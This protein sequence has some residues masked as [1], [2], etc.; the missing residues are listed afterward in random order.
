[1]ITLFKE[2]ENMKKSI[3]IGI[4]AVGI[5][6]LFF[7]FWENLSGNTPEFAKEYSI[8]SLSCDRRAKDCT[9]IIL[10]FMPREEAEQ[11]IPKYVVQEFYK[12]GKT[13]IIFYDTINAGTNFTYN[14]IIKNPLIEELNYYQE[15]EN[16]VVEIK[17]KGAF[18]PA[19]ITANEYAVTIRLKEG[20]QDYPV[21]FDQ[22][23]AEN[24]AVYP[25]FRKISFKTALKSPL[26][27][28]IIQL[29]NKTIEPAMTEIS[30]NQYLFEFYGNIAKDKEY[31]IKAIITDEKDRITVKSWTFEGQIFVETVLGKDR[32]KYLGWWGEINANGVSVRKKPESSSEKLGTFSSINRVKVLK[33]VSGENIDDNNLWYEIDG[34]VYPG[35]YVFSEYVTPI[36][37]P[38]PPQKFTIPG[39]VEK[40]E[41]WIDVDLTKK[42]ITL[43][44]YDKPVFSSY[45]SPGREENPTATGTFRVWYKLEKARMKGGPP[46]HQYKYDLAD[47]PNVLYYEGSYAIHGTYWH[48]KFG[49]QQSAGCTNLTRGDA[50]FIFGRVNPKLGPG[51]EAIFSSKD[52]PGTVVHNHY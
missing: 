41:Y 11:S 49:T 33:E 1:M 9:Q 40:G 43:F 10:N 20:D 46:L 15:G 25:V 21:I 34:G 42:I 6:S 24:S 35:A 13:K 30:P 18:L 47:V 50:A 22:K 45:V 4:L 8:S 38:E 44:S 16:F 19:E 31:S 36:A 3:V 12:Q 14:E 17:R 27:K 28:A 2:Q 37:Q 5:A 48:D 26:K 7:L 51:E 23:P 29:Q 52:N 39:E 32:F